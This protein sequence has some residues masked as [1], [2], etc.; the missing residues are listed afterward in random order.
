MSR[1]RKLADGE[2]STPS[3]RRADGTFLH[4]IKCC[5]CGLKHLVQYKAGRA[6]LR[7]R[8]WRGK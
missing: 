8:A 7:F 6:T 4:R 1:Y 2:W 3:R 5:D